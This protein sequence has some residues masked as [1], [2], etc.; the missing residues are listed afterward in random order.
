MV[1]MRSRDCHTFA[2]VHTQ[3]GMSHDR[4][5]GAKG[6]GILYRTQRSFLPGSDSYHVSVQKMYLKRWRARMEDEGLK[7]SNEWLWCGTVS[8]MWHALNARYED[9]CKRAWNVCVCIICFTGVCVSCTC[10]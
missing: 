9:E 8:G 10:G 7:K 5:I 3:R 1:Y 6:K 4:A 2:Y